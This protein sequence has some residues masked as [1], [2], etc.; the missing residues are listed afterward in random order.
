[1]LPRAASGPTHVSGIII[2]Q[3]IISG[4]IMIADSPESAGFLEA[5]KNIHAKRAV[6]RSRNK[7]AAVKPPGESL[8]VG[9]CIISLTLSLA[10]ASAIPP[11]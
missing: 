5:I 11:V 2:I 4:S 6:A 8:N 1:M 10:P 9:F 7:P 3:G